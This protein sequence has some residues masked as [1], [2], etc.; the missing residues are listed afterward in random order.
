MPLRLKFFFVVLLCINM[1]SWVN[2]QEALQMQEPVDGLRLHVFKPITFG[3]NILGRSH[4]ASYLGL[5]GSISL[6]L[7]PELLEVGVGYQLCVFE[8]TDNRLFGTANR[9]IQHF[10]FTQ[11]QYSF[12]KHKSW[13]VE[14]NLGGGFL[15]LNPTGEDS[16]IKGTWGGA[17]KTG[18]SG[19]YRVSKVISFYATTQYV[20][21]FNS[22]NAPSEFNS[23]FN[24]THQLQFGLGVFIN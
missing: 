24:R 5:E 10:F 21:G 14:A 6:P 19:F 16:R 8:K 4:E 1:I 7:V 11:L 12:F 22:I 15:N 2:A 23:F 18:V 17:A 9:T 13:R 3:N 20:M